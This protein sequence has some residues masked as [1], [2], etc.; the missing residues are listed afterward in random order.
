[1]RRGQR[2]A[3]VACRE[4]GAGARAR[5][6]ID[7]KAVRRH[8]AQ[9]RPRADD[10]RIAQ[11]RKHAD[12]ARRDRRED[13]RFRPVVEPRAPA[14][15]RR[16]ARCLRRSGGSCQLAWRGTAACVRARESDPCSGRPVR[17]ARPSAPAVRCRGRPASTMRSQVNAALSVR[18][19]KRPWRGSM[20]MTSSRWSRTA[21]ARS[22][23]ACSARKSRSGLQS[24]SRA[25]HV[26]P[27]TSGP[28]PGSRSRHAGAI[29]DF[30]VVAFE[31]RLRE[32]PREA[33]GTHIELALATGQ[34][35]RPPACRSATSMPVSSRKRAARRG[36]AR[37]EP[38]VHVPYGAKPDPCPAPRSSR[39][40]R[41]LRDA[42]HRLRRT[43]R[44]C[45]T[46]RAGR[47]RSPRRPVR[48]RRR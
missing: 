23:P 21:P 12:R 28:T 47:R 36:Q 11:P 5:L 41:A 18:T 29:E 10:T 1:M 9:R 38:C 17:Q 24:P 40:C 34:T 22:S 26:P 20:A 14:A 46:D 6:R 7:R 33:F 44:A 35:C 42:R 37:A 8:D 13:G 45:S 2:D 32:Q 25:L 31:S 43:R 4:K 30:D 16:A 3:A 15:N 27:V 39:S 48:R 19:A